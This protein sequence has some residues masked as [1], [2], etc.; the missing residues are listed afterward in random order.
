MNKKFTY[1]HWEGQDEYVILYD[2]PVGQTVTKR[3]AEI[4]TKWLDHNFPPLRA[5][6]A[7]EFYEKGIRAAAEIVWDNEMKEVLL[8]GI[9]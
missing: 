9:D 3:E 5:K 4:I 1:E 2:G 7:K 8:A 6:I